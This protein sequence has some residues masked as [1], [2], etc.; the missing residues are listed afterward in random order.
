MPLFNKAMV[1]PWKKPARLGGTRGRSGLAKSALDIR[2]V[3][4]DNRGVIEPKKKIDQTFSYDDL[5]RLKDDGPTASQPWHSADFVR[6]YFCCY[7]LS[8]TRFNKLDVLL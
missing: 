8:F 2:D 5:C 4:V 1:F 3:L 7:E 6:W